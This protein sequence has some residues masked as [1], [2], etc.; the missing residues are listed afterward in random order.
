[1]KARKVPS[2]LAEGALVVCFA[3]RAPAIGPASVSDRTPPTAHRWLVVA[4]AVLICLA[5][6]NPSLGQ[7]PALL[8]P[9]PSAAPPSAAPPSADAKLA[10]KALGQPGEFFDLTANPGES[11]P[12]TV[13]VATFGAQP[14]AARTYPADAYTLI[15]GGFGARL[16]TDPRGGT[17]TWTDYKEAVLQL[18]PGTAVN[19]PFNL[20]I[21][22]GTP[23]GQYITS[24][25]IENDQPIEGSGKIAINQVQRAAIALSVTVPGP[26]TPGLGFGSAKYTETG[27]FGIVAVQV[28]NTG[29]VLLKPSGTITVK[30]DSGVQVFEAP[31]AMDS[32]YAFTQSQLETQL[33]DRLATGDYTATLILTDQARGTSATS[34]SLPFTVGATP[35]KGPATGLAKRISGALK[36]EAFD[37]GLIGA[38]VLILLIIFELRRRRR[39]RS[40]AEDHSVRTY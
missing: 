26:E 5:P 24:L 11:R 30:N 36:N 25:V 39:K 14:I 1:M 2:V 18:T 4:V 10:I 6:V 12:L 27:G 37:A 20:T 9:S 29:N 21:P 8:S 38:V 23:P 13:E 15:N 35:G 19:I 34:E 22:P 16:R 32:F 33:K 31:V 17:T 40:R 7:T 3:S 28:K